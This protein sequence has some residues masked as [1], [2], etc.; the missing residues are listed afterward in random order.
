MNVMALGFTFKS[1]AGLAMLTVALGG[2][3]VAAGDEID[4]VLK[5]TATW[6]AE[7]GSR[8]E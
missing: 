3:A 6:A 1:Y 2:V 8:P 7:L 5:Q 4:M